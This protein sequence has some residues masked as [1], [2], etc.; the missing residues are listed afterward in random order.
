MADFRIAEECRPQN[1]TDPANGQNQVLVQLVLSLALGVSAFFG[2]CCL[3]PRWKSLYAARQRNIHAAE[4]LP[5]LPDTF[6]GWMPVLYR[7][8]EEQVLASAGLDAYVFLSFFKMSIKLFSIMFL[9]TVTILAPIN[10]HFDYL[11]GWNSTS[12]PLFLRGELMIDLTETVSNDTSLDLSYLW[13]YLVFTYVFT[14]MAIYFL[15]QETR[16]IIRTR[17]DYL[18]SQSTITDRTIKLSGIPVDLRSEEKITELIEKLEIGKVES[19]TLCRNWRKLDDMLD[20]RAH[21]LR[22]LEE[23]WTAHLGGGNIAEPPDSLPAAQPNHPG[24]GT[25]NDDANNNEQDNLLGRD[26]V[27][28]YDKPRPTARIWYGF[29]GLQSKTVDA[30][31]LYEEKLRKLDDAI[32]EARKRFYKPTSLAFVTMDSIAACQMATQ[33]LLDPSPM[34]LLANLAP[35]PSDIVWHNTYLPRS[36]R[37]IRSWTITIFILVLTIFWLIPVGALAGLVDLCSIRKVWPQLADLL[38]RHD[39]I[40]AL[41]QTGLPT[42]V[43]SLLNVAV[44]FLYDYLANNQGSISQGEVELSVISKNFYFTFFNVFIVFTVFGAAS[45]FWPLLQ[46]S[47]KD[48]T[49]LAYHLA[50]SI[51]ELAMFYTN[52]ILLQGVGLLPF[53]LL[54]FGSV[55]LYPFYLLSAKTP[56]DRA[57]MTQPPLF[58]Y[59]FYL[60]SAI[61]VYILCIVYSILP[62]G[63]MVLFFGL[64]YFV[65]GY[66][67]Y[68][69]QLLYAMD[70]PQHATGGAWPMICYRILVGLAVFQVAMAGLI[71][72]KKAFTPAALVV[73]LIP[74]TIWY[75]YYFGRTF[76]PLTKFI[77]LR[78]IRREDDPDVNIADEDVGISRPPGHYRRSSTI[79]ESREK[80]MKFINPSLVTPLQKLWIDKAPETNGE[81][82]EPQ[83]DREESTA[84]SVSSA[85]TVVSYH[86]TLI[87]DVASN[88]EVPDTM[89]SQ[90][91]LSREVAGHEDP[92]SPSASERMAPAS[93]TSMFESNDKYILTL[94]DAAT[95][96][97]LMGF[98]GK[99]CSPDEDA[100]DNSDRNTTPLPL[101]INSPE[102]QPTS[103]SVTSSPVDMNDF[104]HSLNGPRADFTAFQIETSTVSSDVAS[105]YMTTHERVVDKGK[106][107]ERVRGRELERGTRF[108]NPLDKAES[109]N[110]KNDAA[111]ELDVQPIEKRSR[112]STFFE[113]PS[114]PCAVLD[115]NLLEPCPHAPICSSVSEVLDGKSSFQRSDVGSHRTRPNP[116]FNNTSRQSPTDTPTRMLTTA[117]SNCRPLYPAPTWPPETLSQVLPDISYLEYLAIKSSSRFWSGPTSRSGS[118]STPKPLPAVSKLPAEILHLIYRN[119]APGDFNS[120]R[121]S[122]RA[123]YISSLEQSILDLMLKRGGWFSSSCKDITANHRLGSQSGVRVSDEWLMSKHIARECALGPNWAGNGL[124][125][126]ADETGTKHPL[127]QSST[128]DFTEVTTYLPSTNSAGT[129]FTVSSCGRFLMTANGCLVYVY[130]LN[131][132]PSPAED[133][134][135]VHPGWLRP[136][137]SIICPRQVLACSMDTSSHRYAIAI[138]LD[139][140]MGLVCDISTSN[141]TPRKSSHHYDNPHSSKYPDCILAAD[142]HGRESSHT[143]AYFLDRVSL[144][145]SASHVASSRS[146]TEPIVLPGIAATG[147]NV[148][149][150]A[151]K[152]VW[153]DIPRSEQPGSYST[154][155]SSRHARLP[156]M[157][158]LTPGSQSRGVSSPNP[159]QDYA[160]CSMPI[161]TGP[162]SLYRNLCSDD[163]PPRSVAI[164][165]QR[166]CVAFGCSAGIELHWVDALTGQDLNRWF[167]LTASS[168]YLFFLPPRK[169]VDSAKKLRLI[170]S[171]AKPSERAAIS[172]RAFGG[173]TRSSPF[174]EIFGWGQGEAADNTSIDF[175]LGDM[176]R[177]GGDWGSFASGS[178]IDSSDHYRAV[179]LSDGYHILFTDPTTGFLCLGSDAPVGGPTKLLRKI[180]FQGPE[181]KGSPLS[182]AAGSDLTWGTRVVAAYGSGPEQTIWLFSVPGDV[183][184]SHQGPLVSPLN[185]SFWIRGESC[186]E[187]NHI[188]WISWWPD[189]GLQEWLRR[190]QDPVPGIMPRSIWPVRVCGQE[191]GTCEGVVDLAVDSCSQVTIWAFSKSGIAKIWE[192]DDGKS[193]IARN[194]VVARDGMVRERVDDRD[195]GEVVMKDSFSPS[196]ESL[197]SSTAFPGRQQSFDGTSSLYDSN[198]F[199]RCADRRSNI[200]SNQHAALTDADGDVLMEDLPPFET[201]D[202][203]DESFEAVAFAHHMPEAAYRNAQW[204]ESANRS[205]INAVGSDIVEELTG[206]ARIDIEIR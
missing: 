205:Q 90:I 114:D 61:L 40:K 167:P 181:G 42:L 36:S 163:D 110:R 145:S 139:G 105:I 72:L 17:Q 109:R 59:G 150:Y 1:P 128:V 39:I 25:P 89:S 168:D 57:Q 99:P 122:C 97:H 156:R 185:G 204:S 77:A 121:H 51:Q 91:L 106:G 80:G 172:E 188:D 148:Q 112:S 103:G 74:F 88:Q 85:M 44:P 175:G 29:L 192:I 126:H 116:S 144:N 20:K 135:K 187:T 111:I 14:G 58:K 161:E 137:T 16:R 184:T 136:V 198:A 55:F 186:R 75:S 196:P 203:E 194:V 124:P 160:K 171:A 84:S 78:S 41:V 98:D 68:K 166:R 182:Y 71:A 115:D 133:C 179:P 33:A 26:H 53:R 22:R 154:R 27:T 87:S 30:I 23:A 155:R 70:H 190:T 83:L 159:V 63:Y 15:T 123:W 202:S 200:E 165:P 24:I 65:F 13:A 46:K 104:E 6:F 67:T 47:L 93:I 66:Y 157:H 52:F 176:A 130:E 32:K 19:V 142:D 146:V 189:H 3:R 147:P 35:A 7:V 117:F 86:S 143:S 56:R 132:R 125:R 69:Y 151:D 118:L 38:E 54:E 92:T 193:C 149:S 34:Q 131:R 12:S 48:T 2:F 43:V 173:K 101:Y 49:S 96:S 138:L 183:F 141:I 64:I 95:A 180:W 73:P 79:D 82:Q 10:K 28:S 134:S 76:E 162:R 108:Q 4:D 178:R 164:C 60:P 100:D 11:P 169:S 195:D 158:P 153:Q 197:E 8:T 31:D 140:R 120:A 45:K 9:L 201:L 119:L 113:D 177:Y 107:K 5:E 206:M 18:G 81:G 21:I 37:M 50:Q 174:W 129:I 127:R 191:I 170:S 152:S 94:G 62:A 102:L 199:A